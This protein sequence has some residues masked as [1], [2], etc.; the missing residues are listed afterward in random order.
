MYHTGPQ[1]PMSDPEPEGPPLQRWVPQ[2]NPRAHLEEMKQC[3]DSATPTN[4]A[5]ISTDLKSFIDKA[6]NDEWQ[7]LIDYTCN[8]ASSATEH[9]I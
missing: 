6:S 5:Q 4:F 7:M 9:K 1:T 2:P 3:I 8:E